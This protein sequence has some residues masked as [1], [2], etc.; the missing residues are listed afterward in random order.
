MSS[1]TDHV[2]QQVDHASFQEG[3]Q[4]FNTMTTAS[5]WNTP[6]FNTV[7]RGRHHS[8]GILGNVRFPEMTQPPTNHLNTVRIVQMEMLMTH[9]KSRTSSHPEL[10]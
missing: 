1:G 9:P 4:E 6:V 7:D 3:Y 8:V 2:H 5:P 10:H